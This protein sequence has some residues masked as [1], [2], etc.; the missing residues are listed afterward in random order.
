[1]RERGAKQV[2]TPSSDL[3]SG[4]VEIKTK[5]GGM[6][7]KPKGSALVEPPRSVSSWLEDG[8]A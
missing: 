8:T 3:I 6:K 1:V 7:K 2:P 4:W 5:N